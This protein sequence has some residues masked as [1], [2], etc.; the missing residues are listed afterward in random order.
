MGLKKL[1]WISDNARQ[2]NNKALPGFAAE[3]VAKNK[4]KENCKT[5][6]EFLKLNRQFHQA[7]AELCPE[8]EE[9]VYINSEPG[10]SKSIADVKIC[11]ISFA[12]KLQLSKRKEIMTLSDYI[13]ACREGCAREKVKNKQLH[14]NGEEK[15]TIFVFEEINESITVLGYENPCF[16]AQIKGKI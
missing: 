15:E 1:Y 6:E 5:V 7:A 10:H 12:A 16:F 13:E 4:S 11:Q 3:I 9:I 14:L 2:F 8:L